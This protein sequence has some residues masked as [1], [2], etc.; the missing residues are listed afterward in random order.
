MTITASWAR[1][2]TQPVYVGMHRLAVSRVLFIFKVVPYFH[3]THSDWAQCLSRHSCTHIVII[4][5]FVCRLLSRPW[6]I[7]ITLIH[8]TVLQNRQKN[9]FPPHIFLNCEESPSE[10]PNS[11]FNF[12][13]SILEI[14]VSNIWFFLLLKTFFIQCYYG[15]SF[16]QNCYVYLFVWLV[17]YISVFPNLIERAKN[18]FWIFHEL[19]QKT[20]PT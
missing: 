3:T 8:Y 2:T 16:P 5:V 17:G 9:L 13:C 14:K 6:I 7:V 12:V 4:V 18:T 1:I 11:E 20:P 15:F 10:P 19:A